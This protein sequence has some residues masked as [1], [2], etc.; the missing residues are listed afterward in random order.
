MR[1]IEPVMTDSSDR[2][3]LGA[4]LG[5][6]GGLGMW[7]VMIVVTTGVCAV[8]V[9]STLWCTVLPYA[10]PSTYSSITLW[11]VILLI[12]FIGIGASTGS[13]ASRSARR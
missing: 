10:G 12:I 2:S 11:D 6:L 13:R 4:V 5:A 3:I 1:A 8:P 9:L 7:I